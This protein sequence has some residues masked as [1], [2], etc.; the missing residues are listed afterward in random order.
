M[1]REL[2]KM[3]QRYQAVMAVQVEGLAVTE[4]ADRFDVSR[5]T[6]HEWLRR[7]EAGGVVTWA[8]AGV[9]GGLLPLL[10][11]A[12]LAAWMWARRRRPT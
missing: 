3:E 2:S 9:R 8:P 1:L 5:Q 11:V 6:V 4:V 10:L 12:G 7:Y